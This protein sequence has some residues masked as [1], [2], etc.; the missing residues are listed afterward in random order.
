MRMKDRKRLKENV[1]KEM[2]KK[3][4]KTKEKRVK[5]RRKKSEI[6][7]GITDKNF[8]KGLYIFQAEERKRK[9]V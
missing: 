7:F 3:K 2:K 6:M 4:K 8:N 5:Q 1:Y 9:K